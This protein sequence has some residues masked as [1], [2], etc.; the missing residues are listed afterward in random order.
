MDLIKVEKSQILLVHEIKLE[1]EDILQNINYIWHGSF[2]KLV[3]SIIT[4][5]LRLD[6]P[7]KENNKI[8]VMNL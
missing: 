5:I 8:R 3:I 7:L 4:L 1:E 2:E 6:G